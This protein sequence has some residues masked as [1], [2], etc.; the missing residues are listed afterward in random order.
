M[1]R[2]LI[3]CSAISFIGA[4]LSAQ[5]PKAPFTAKDAQAGAKIAEDLLVMR[6]QLGDAKQPAQ[7]FKIAGNL[8]FVGVSNGECYLLTSPQGHILMGVGFSDTVDLVAKN[9]EAAGFKLA[10]IKVI[11]L[12]HG[13]G[14]QSGGAAEMKRRTGAQVAAGFAEVPF[15]EHGGV[16]PGGVPRPANMPTPPPAPPNRLDKINAQF[17]NSNQYPPV[18]VDRALFDGDV[19]TVGPLKVTA[20]LAPGHS[21]SSTSFSYEVTDGGKK[22]HVLEMCCWEFPDDIRNN[23]YITE[24]NVAHTLAL[25]RKMLPVDIYLETGLYGASGILNQTGM[26]QERLAKLRENPKLW[27]NRDIFKQLSAAREVEYA[28]KLAKAKAAGGK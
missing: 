26:Y 16:W 10:D 9:I 20:Y 6:E 5:A 12:N 22:L 11:L 14:D 13:H 7:Q 17:R 19:V 27:I 25:F 28:E 3:L 1:Y 18:K 15:L 23:A 24:A 21:P 8:Y 2:K 4:T